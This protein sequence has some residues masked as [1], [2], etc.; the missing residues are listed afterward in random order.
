M[1]ARPSAFTLTAPGPLRLYST[2]ELLRLPPPTWLVGGI[3]PEGSLSVLYGPPESG[4]SFLA[5][6]LALSVATGL[7]WHGHPVEQGFVVYVAAEGGSGISKRVRAWLEAK[8]V[9]ARGVPVAW[10]V[11]SLTVNKESDDVGRLMQ[12]LDDELEHTPRLIVVDTLARCLEGDENTQLDVGR[13]VAGVDM[14]RHEYKAAVM[15]VHHTRLDGDR[16]R[17]NTALRGGT[18]TM[19]SATKDENSILVE[20][21]KQKDWEHFPPLSVTLTPV[22]D[23]ESC[24]LV[25]D[26][27]GREAQLLALFIG[28]TAYSASE[29]LARAGV[30]GMSRK[31]FFRALGDTKQ[32]GRI[33]KENGKYRLAGVTSDTP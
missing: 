18:D 17:G 9:A 14:L 26:T 25:S 3:L 30:T 22:R 6:D 11:E 29:L 5:I 16:E 10:L 24:I 33:L 32:S 7:P 12:R 15:I 23:T 8:Q 31:T 19:L 27:V 21:T 2:E 13:F 1:G 4:K 28:E 20:C